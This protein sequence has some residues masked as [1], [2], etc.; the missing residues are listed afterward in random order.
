M[1]VWDNKDADRLLDVLLALGTKSEA[2]KFLRDLM[3]GKEITD[4]SLRWKVA[5]M[6][7][8]EIPYSK[9]EEKTG[10]SSATIARISKWLHEG[11]GG[12]RI[13][14]KKMKNEWKR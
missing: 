8:N 11:D 1:S 13:M 6:L 3:T 10:L 7:H 9:I 4:M 12:Y 5:C 2:K 14:L